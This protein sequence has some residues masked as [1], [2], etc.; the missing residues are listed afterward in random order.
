[1]YINLRITRLARR[2]M[3]IVI[4]ELK[5]WCGL[6][7]VKGPIDGTHISIV[8]PQCDFVEDDYCTK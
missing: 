1:V 2:E 5:K 6:L 3:I 4:E 8:K 7:S